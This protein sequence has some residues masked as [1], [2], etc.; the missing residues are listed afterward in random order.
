MKKSALIL[1][2]LFSLI[3]LSAG[4]EAFAEK[5]SAL[6]AI[7]PSQAS[8]DAPPPAP[9]IDTPPAPQP[10]N[11]FGSGIQGQPLSAPRRTLD[12]PNPQGGSVLRDD[13]GQGWTPPAQPVDNA[14]YE[15][16]I[17]RLEQMTFGSPYP[18]HEVE[19]RLDHLENEVFNKKNTGMPAD[20]RVARLESKLLGQTAFGQASAP[21]GPP[22]GPGPGPSSQPW[23]GGGAASSGYYPVTQPPQFNPAPYQSPQQQNQR[24]Y[25]SGPP[26]QN[27]YSGFPQY[28]QG[29]SYQAPSRQ[30]QPPQNNP[31][32]GPQNPYG[33]APVQGV[34][35]YQGTAQGRPYNQP[36]QGQPQMGYQGAPPQQQQ[37]Y[38]SQMQPAPQMQA[39]PQMQFPPQQAPNFSAPP[40]SQQNTAVQ[41][42]QS[43]PVTQNNP[44]QQALTKPAEPAKAAANSETDNIVKSIPVKQGI[45]DYFGSISRF[46]NGSVARWKSFPVLVHLPEGSPAPWHKA[47]TESVES[48]GR[49]LP[50]R[51]AAASESADIEIGW[52]NHLPP[53]ALGQTNL[54][55]FNGRM[56]VTVYLL[57]P[58][59]YLPET[60]QKVLRKV[61]EHEVGHAIG[62]FGHSNDPYDM[63]F[64]IENLSTKE[65]TKYSAI[66]A[67]DLNTLRRIYETAPLPSN[68]QSP[69][70]MGWSLNRKN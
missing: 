40:A 49:Y 3:W 42:A 22:V 18:E 41:P 55:V 34:Q 67:R 43:S 39:P 24:P 64:P 69:H 25:G 36:Y 14:I 54:E 32:S 57:R 19:D 45:G 59:Y 62:I 6:K 12:N 2:S 33:Q 7:D 66:S 48:W 47:L 20:Q 17:S 27:P 46:T 21:T 58:S 63:M 8:Y 61:A 16:R 56:R 38:P 30:Y 1:S 13:S 15:Q 70:P 26:N 65:G 10:A 9:N 44:A 35:G 5:K 37:N 28:S 29:Q 23:N 11:P 4:A 60:S 68:Y 31:Y 50:V 53:R 52:I 51:V